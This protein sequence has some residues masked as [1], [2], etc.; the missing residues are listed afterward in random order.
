VKP[1]EDGVAEL[2]I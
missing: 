2:R 1:P